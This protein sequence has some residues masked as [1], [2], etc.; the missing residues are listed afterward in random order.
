MASD[1]RAA[2]FRKKCLSLA[3]TCSMGLR[4]G[5]YLGRKNSLAP[6][7]RMSWLD[8]FAFVAAEIVHDDDIAG[9]QG[10][11]ENLFDDRARKLS[12][13]IG[14]STSH[15]AS[16]RSW[17][18]AARNVVVFQ[19]PCGTL[20]RSLWPHSAHPR[21]GAMSVLAQVSSMKTSRS[22]STRF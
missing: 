5:E 14:P 12:P 17:R 13:S 11:E 2:A 8:G 21:S 15:G 16:M 6:A 20:A 18:S 7:A 1:V 19:R 9:L 22:G 3:K 10:R 4:S